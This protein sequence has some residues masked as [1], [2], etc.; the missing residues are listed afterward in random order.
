M[1]EPG[2]LDSDAE[3]DIRHAYPLMDEVAREEGWEEPEMD[4]YNTYAPKPSA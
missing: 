3:M 2:D 1:V 4:T